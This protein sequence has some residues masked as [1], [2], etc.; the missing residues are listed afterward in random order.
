[1]FPTCV[2]ILGVYREGNLFICTRLEANSPGLGASL[3]YWSGF[4]ALSSR[5]SHIYLS[6]E[7]IELLALIRRFLHVW[8]AV[9]GN[10]I[11]V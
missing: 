3:A 4:I 5:I 1:M 8:H 11:A 7:G 9:L 10:G 2:V 6:S